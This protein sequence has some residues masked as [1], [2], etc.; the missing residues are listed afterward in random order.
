MTHHEMPGRLCAKNSHPALIHCYDAV[1]SLWDRYKTSVAE[2]TV[3]LRNVFFL[4]Q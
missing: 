4:P 1:G 3:C 2:R